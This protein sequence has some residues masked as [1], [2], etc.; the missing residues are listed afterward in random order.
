MHVK[1]GNKR[2]AATTN[3]LPR[4]QRTHYTHTHTYRQDGKSETKKEE[5]EDEYNN[6]KNNMGHGEILDNTKKKGKPIK[7]KKNITHLI[8]HRFS[9][10]LCA[11]SS[12]TPL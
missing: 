10:L 8:S 7:M 6:N 11:R 5:D 4:L 9:S 2:R 12:R 3:R 1:L